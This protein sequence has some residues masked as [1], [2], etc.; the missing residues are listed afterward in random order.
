MGWICWI[1]KPLD[2]RLYLT[3]QQWEVPELR[4]GCRSDEAL[5][6]CFGSKVDV[7]QL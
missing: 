6:L 1:F 5:R 2:A 3:A 7:C 4:A